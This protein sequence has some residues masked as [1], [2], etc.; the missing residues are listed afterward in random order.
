MRGYSGG[1]TAG[2]GLV[3]VKSRVVW[4]LV[5]VV[6]FRVVA[7]WFSACCVVMPPGVS[8]GRRAWP[9][10]VVV[11]TCLSNPSPEPWP[12]IPHVNPLI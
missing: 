1:C 3:G 9:A 5:E 6:S 11:V 12:P 8:W 7:C 2:E 4:R 10:F